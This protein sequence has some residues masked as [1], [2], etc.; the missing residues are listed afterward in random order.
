MAKNK[1]Q[2]RGLVIFVAVAT[3]ISLAGL[4]GLFGA[5]IPQNN[6]QDQ[7]NEEVDINQIVAVT[8]VPCLTS[9]KFHLHPHL[10]ILV[11]GADEALPADI[12]V[13]P[14][15]TQELHTHEADGIIHVESDVDKGYTLQNFL[16]V[17]GFSINQPGFI[18]RL[19]VDGEF[20]GN[21]ANFRLEDGQ[22]IT[23]EFI[24]IPE[25]GTGTEE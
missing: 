17:T 20:N 14:G 11:D 4:T 10:T 7:Q 12:G 25:L 24:S 3:T 1:K 6:N 5:G 9:E 18:T 22:Q 15:C 19:T 23:L 16:N 2:K 13:Y 21:D 8:G